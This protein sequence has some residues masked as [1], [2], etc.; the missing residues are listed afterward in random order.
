MA[1]SV[2]KKPVKKRI[3]QTAIDEI[4]CEVSFNHKPIMVKEDMANRNRPQLENQLIRSHNISILYDCILPDN[5]T[6]SNG[7]KQEHEAGF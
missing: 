4:G 6:I 5:F 2:L 7:E 3:Q 1:A